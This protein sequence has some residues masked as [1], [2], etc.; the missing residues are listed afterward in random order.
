MHKENVVTAA[1]LTKKCVFWLPCWRVCH[2]GASAVSELQQQI[3]LCFLIFPSETCAK[4]KEGGDIPSG[5]HPGQAAL[6]PVGGGHA[7]L[8]GRPAAGPGLLEE[9]RRYASPCRLF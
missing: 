9:P 7:L 4:V 1:I 5:F 6:W 2:N 3:F 8:P